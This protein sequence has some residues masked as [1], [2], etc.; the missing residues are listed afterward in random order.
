[1][2]FAATRHYAA[3]N[4][5]AHQGALTRTA[6]DPGIPAAIYIMR[7]ML[8][9][10]HRLSQCTRRLASSSMQN[11][12]FLHPIDTNFLDLPATPRLSL[13]SGSNVSSPPS[14]CAFLL[15]GPALA[16]GAFFNS[17]VIKGVK[18][19]S[20][21]RFSRLVLNGALLLHQ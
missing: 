21:L 10:V 16:N 7:T 6:A 11:S 17:E 8:T 14:T 3:A 2:L 19:G 20:L 13:L 12:P 15:P 5:H 18:Q 1:M 9:S 4:Q